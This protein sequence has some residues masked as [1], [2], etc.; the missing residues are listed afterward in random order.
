MTT[1]GTSETRLK[2]QANTSIVE[3]IPIGISSFILL[4]KVVPNTEEMRLRRE[5]Y[6]INLL[7]TK[8]PS[9]L[10]KYCLS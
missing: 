2:P 10:N 8:E 9:G 1:L 3:V 7:Q 5:D 4:K 6:W